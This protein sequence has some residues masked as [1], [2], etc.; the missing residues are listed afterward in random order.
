M[1]HKWIKGVALGSPPSNINWSDIIREKRISL[2]HREL[3][4]QLQENRTEIG[5]GKL[6]LPHLQNVPAEVLFK[7]RQDEDAFSRF[8]HALSNF[9]KKSQESDTESKLLDCMKEVDYH[10]HMLNQ[11]FKNI[12]KMRAL[13]TRNVTLQLFGLGLVQLVPVEFAADLTKFLGSI[14][15]FQAIEHFVSFRE[16]FDKLKENDFYFPWR[17][18]R[19]K[20]K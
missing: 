18:A 9:L 6:Y 16:K 11:Q 12:K 19:A 7:L 4:A 17:I 3:K 1:P 15:A 14:T 8:Q 2:T 20:R 5:M 10:I 13:R